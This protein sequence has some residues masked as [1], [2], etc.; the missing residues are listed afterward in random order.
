MRTNRFDQMRFRLWRP[1]WWQ[2]ALLAAL[3]IAVVLAVAIVATSL[4]LI[5]APIALIAVIAHR[6]FARRAVRP[7][8]SGDP[9]ARH[10]VIE[11]DYEVITP[12]PSDRS[13]PDERR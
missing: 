5:I 13:D 2:L 4:I 11:A 9:R 12:R 6:L 3:A 7:G 8:G 1:A 10:Q